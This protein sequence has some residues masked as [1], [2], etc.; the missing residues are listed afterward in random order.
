MTAPLA[1]LTLVDPICRAHGVELVDLRLDREPGGQILKIIIDRET[2][3]VTLGDCQ[4]VSRDVGTALDV[5]EVISGRYRL[6]VGSP[7]LDRPL[8]TL[9]HFV[10]FTNEVARITT[11]QPIS[12]RRNFHGKL[13][14]VEGEAIRLE[15]DGAEVRIPHVDILKANLVYDWGR[16]RAARS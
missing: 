16:A 15:Q 8:V 10:R 14:G 1:L 5:H 7:G 3:G 6:E 12:G 2:S 11:K 4:Q 9:Q 13:L